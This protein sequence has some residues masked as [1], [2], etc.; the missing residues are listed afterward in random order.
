MDMR[1]NGARQ[2]L[3]FHIS[4]ERNIIV[5]RLGMRHTHGVLL[6]DRPFVEISS[7]V[8]CRRADQLHAALIGL[9]VRVGSLEARQEGMVDV[10]DAADIFLHRSSDRTCM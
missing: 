4:T 3:R 10:N 9:F 7:D 2:H 5:R 1:V 8:M 6:D